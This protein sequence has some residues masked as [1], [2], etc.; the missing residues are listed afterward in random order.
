MK[1]VTY[2]NSNKSDTVY[3]RIKELVIYCCFKPG[4]QLQ[5][6][7]LA[8]R[9]LTSATPVREALTRLHAEALVTAVQNRGFFA[10]ALEARKLKESQELAFVILRH[11]VE[12][13]VAGFCTPGVPRAIDV[14]HAFDEK[15]CEN[16][17]EL[18]RSRAVFVEQLYERIASLSGSKTMVDQIQVFNEQSRFVQLIDFE[19]SHDIESIAADLSE[20]VAALERQ[21][22]LAAVASMERHFRR[23]LDRIEVLVKEGNNRALMGGNDLPPFLAA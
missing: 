6:S 7:N 23:K 17:E 19:T 1:F 15:S 8:S 9:L 16:P 14:L 22:T 3:V 2:S 20:L 18:C 21:D 11:A 13:N 4:Q 12:R 10:K 5:I